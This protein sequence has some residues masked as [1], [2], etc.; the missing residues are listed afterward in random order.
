[1]KLNQPI[2]MTL[3]LLL[4][5]GTNLFAQMDDP[6][7][8]LN[9]RLWQTN[10]TMIASVIQNGEV[11]KRGM[12][13]GFFDDGLVHAKDSIGNDPYGPYP[14]HLF[15]MLHADYSWKDGQSVHFKVYT[16][17]RMYTYYPDPPLIYEDFFYYGIGT[18]K[19]PYIIDITPDSLRD[20]IDNTA[21]LRDLDAKPTTVVLPNRVIDNE[22]N[23]LTVPFDV[24]GEQLNET[25][26]QGWSL[27]EFGNSSLTDGVLSLEFKKANAMEAGKPYFIRVSDEVGSV[28]NP[29]FADVKVIQSAYEPSTTPFVDFLPTLNPTLLQ[30]NS[31]LDFLI[32][33]GNNTLYNPSTLDNAWMKG[34]RGFFQ[35]HDLPENNASGFRL[36]FDADD[37]VSGIITLENPTSAPSD[38]YNLMGQRVEKVSGSRSIQIFH[39]KK[40]IYRQ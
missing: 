4:L 32:L 31:I 36:V 19:D 1:M 39:N 16:G 23:T 2:L 22:W 6:F 20:V 27:Y 13:A 9:Y 3:V 37:D 30:G 29:V 7:P 26:G 14:H 34:F 38:I 24:T 10:G 25:F 5:G 28:Q 21:Q 35:L 8:V 40:I 33:G 18:C 17:G 12:V 15:I 11:V